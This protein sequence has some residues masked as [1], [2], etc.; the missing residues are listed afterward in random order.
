MTRFETTRGRRDKGGPYR[1]LG[2]EELTI[3]LCREEGRKKWGGIQERVW[4]GGSVVAKSLKN[5]RQLLWGR[6]MREA[7]RS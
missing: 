3:L 4:E 2:T 6:R 1:P 5:P 7:S